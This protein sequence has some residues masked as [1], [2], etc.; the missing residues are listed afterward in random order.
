MHTK[1]FVIMQFLSFGVLGSKRYPLKANLP[2]TTLLLAG[3]FFF[4]L[5]LTNSIDLV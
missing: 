3:L 4:A 1:V 2:F 5:K